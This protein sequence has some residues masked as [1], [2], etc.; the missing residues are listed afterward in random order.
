[1]KNRAVGTVIKKKGGEQ[2]K[3]RLKL[4]D[5]KNVRQPSTKAS[6]KTGYLKKIHQSD[7]HSY[8]KYYFTLTKSRLLYLSKKKDGRVVGEIPLPCG[9]NTSNVSSNK[10]YTFELLPSHPSSQHEKKIVLAADTEEQMNEWIDAIREASSKIFYPDELKGEGKTRDG[11][12]SDRRDAR[13][14]FSEKM[15]VDDDPNVVI[16]YKLK[17]ML[18]H[19]W[20]QMNE[21]LSNWRSPVSLRGLCSATTEDLSEEIYDSLTLGAIDPSLM[22]P[23]RALS[24]HNVL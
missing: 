4:L 18:S 8:G 15:L 5:L 6:Q 14:S 10:K 1:M 9:I 19:N 20:F 11:G 16:G 17:H 12:S 2:K 24:V 22:L 21:Q 13:A 3:F 23:S 7:S